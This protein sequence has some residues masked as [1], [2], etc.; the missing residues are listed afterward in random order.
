MNN[1]QN[2]LI[3]SSSEYAIIS[4]DNVS[5][6]DNFQ[7][8]FANAKSLSYYDS[9]VQS[10]SGSKKDKDILYKYM[11][12]VSNFNKKYMKFKFMVGGKEYIGERSKIDPMI[13]SV[14]NIPSKYNYINNITRN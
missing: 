5:R 14:L 4:Q 9:H 1:C 13:K 11:D 6:C 7:H 10:G 8:I 2:E 3:P 12:I